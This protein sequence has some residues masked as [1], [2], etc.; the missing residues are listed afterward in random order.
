MLVEDVN[1]FAGLNLVSGYNECP[2]CGERKF[3]IDAKVYKCFKPSCVA[4][5]QGK[6][7]DILTL[8][9]VGS[10]RDIL[11]IVSPSDP[12]KYT[13]QRLVMERAFDAYVYCAS[14]EENSYIIGSLNDRAYGTS[15]E[16]TPIGYAPNGTYLQQQG[17]DLQVLKECGLVKPNGEVFYQDRVRCR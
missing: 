12:V 4:N 1:K 15:L 2:F 14:K 10:K 17:L 3:R 16:T 7:Y 8:L 5:K 11:S 6:L 9:N 13:K